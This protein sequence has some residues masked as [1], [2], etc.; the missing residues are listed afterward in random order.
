MNAADLGIGNRCTA[1]DPFSGSGPFRRNFAA[2]ENLTVEIGKIAPIM[3]NNIC[4][5]VFCLNHFS[6]YYIYMIFV[7]QKSL[8]VTFDI[9][10][11]ILFVFLGLLFF[12]ELL[13]ISVD[14][15]KHR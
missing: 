2:S 9:V 6:P 3:G 5:L 13:E 10:R 1:F 15:I 11:V 7:S 8:P 14:T 12:F 4:V